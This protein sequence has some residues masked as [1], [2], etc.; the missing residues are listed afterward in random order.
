[1]VKYVEVSF[2]INLQA[3]MTHETW[4]WEAYRLHRRLNGCDGDLLVW[5]LYIGWRRWCGTSV[6]QDITACMPQWGWWNAM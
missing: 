4:L 2:Q 3:G 1:M 6:C 5:C